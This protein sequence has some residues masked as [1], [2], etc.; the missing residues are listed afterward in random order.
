MASAAPWP[1][2]AGGRTR[3]RHA[4]GGNAE[5]GQP[6]GKRAIVRV[7]RLLLM[8]GTCWYRGKSYVKAQASELAPKGLV[9]EVQMA[10]D[11]RARGSR[12]MPWLGA[13]RLLLTYA[14]TS[15]YMGSGS[16]APAASLTFG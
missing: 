3:E 15:A 4:P 5:P 6:R 8:T 2:G 10:I 16:G 12:A 14:E 7:L 13:A 9:E 1:G 11:G